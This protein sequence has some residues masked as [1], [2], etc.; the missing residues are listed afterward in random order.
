[1]SAWFIK[2]VFTIAVLSMK[3]MYNG[4]M[5][6]YLNEVSKTRTILWK[7]S[8]HMIQLHSPVILPLT[9]LILITDVIT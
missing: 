9:H 1:M 8:E 6:L 4:G 7:N 2:Q 3:L 5:R